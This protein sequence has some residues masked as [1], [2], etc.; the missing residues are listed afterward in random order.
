LDLFG[1]PIG[2][3]GLKS[4]TSLAFFRAKARELKFGKNAFLMEVVRKLK[5]PNNLIIA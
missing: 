4:D 5:F 1:N 2:S 3:H